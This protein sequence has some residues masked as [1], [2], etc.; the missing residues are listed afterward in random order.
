[1]TLP[2][3]SVRLKGQDIVLKLGTEQKNLIV[4]NG[5]S[6]DISHLSQ[7]IHNRIAEVQVKRHRDWVDFYKQMD[8]ERAELLKEY[9]QILDFIDEIIKLCEE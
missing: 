1:M 4:G 5:Y 3:H 7:T 8:K 2:P 9:N 6:D